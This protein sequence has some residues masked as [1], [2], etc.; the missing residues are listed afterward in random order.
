MIVYGDPGFEIPAGAWLARQAHRIEQAR[1]GGQDE[2]RTWLIEAGQLEQALADRLGDSPQ[3]RHSEALTELAADAVLGAPDWER[4]S[5]MLDTLELAPTMLLRIK[6]P[7]GYAYYGLFPEHYARA[8]E[9]WA[10]ECPNC[11]ARRVLVVGLRSIGTGLSAVVARVLARTGRTVRRM[12]VRPTGHPYRRQV[13]IPRSVIGDADFA[14]VVDEGP[15]QSGSSMAATAEALAE[16]GLERSRIVFFPGHG[17]GP[18]TA[19]SGPV[20]D[21]WRNTPCRVGEPDEPVFG[22]QSLAEVLAGRSGGPVARVDELGGGAWR[23]AVYADQCDWPAA[24]SAFERAKYRVVRADG[25]AVLWKFEGLAGAAEESAAR[26]AWLARRGWTEAPLGCALG[27]AARPWVD[28]E[29]LRR[30]QCEPGLLRVI[31]RYIAEAAMPSD[32]ETERRA[33]LERL[34]GMLYRNVRECLGRAAAARA[35]AC[36]GLRPEHPWPTYGDGRLGPA[37]WLRRSDGLLVKVD[38][39]GHRNDHTVVGVQPVV[40]DLAGAMVEWGL[41]GDSARPLLNAFAA[42]GGEPPPPA[43]LTIYR[44]AYAAFRLGMC[45]MCAGA[46]DPAEQR[47]LGQAGEFYRRQLAE[48]L[49]RNR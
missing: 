40:W 10:G 3:L 47:R 35:L 7:E 15:G 41:D 48:L 17:R 38:C 30:E 12:T 20:R 39:V 49:R 23:W 8:A 32:P 5:A 6:K 4:A 9:R 24:Y 46:S 45:V 31:G 18:G 1:H 2:R 29:P 13:K 25:S 28:A 44:L 21:W 43:A 37:E 33:A 11:G 19:A 42:A 34:R 36:E 22:G 14:L 27:F 16:A 26:M